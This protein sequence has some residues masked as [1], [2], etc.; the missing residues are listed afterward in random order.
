MLQTIVYK[1]LQSRRWSK[2]C[3]FIRFCHRSSIS[4]LVSMCVQDGPVES[5]DTVLSPDAVFSPSITVIF[6]TSVARRV[7]KIYMYCSLIC[8]PIRDFA[9]RV[10]FGGHQSSNLFPCGIY[11]D[12]AIAF[13][14]PNSH[15]SGSNCIY[16]L[17]PTQHRIH[18][19]SFQSLFR[20]VA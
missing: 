3:T 8:H 18:N 9:T 4:I 16:V 6:A 13:C 17:P 12:P 5:K 20:C 1:D 19:K 2:I 10:F 15:R 11:W 14:H 7:E